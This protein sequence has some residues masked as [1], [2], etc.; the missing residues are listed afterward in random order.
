MPYDEALFDQLL[1][2]LALEHAEQRARLD[3]LRATLSPAERAARGI[4]LLDVEA[5]DESWGLGGRLL[6][7]LEKPGRAPLE[8]K[9]GVGDVVELRPRRAEVER[10]ARGVVARRTRT[11]VT[12][13]FEQLPP[14][15]VFEGRLVVDLTP[16]DVTFQRAQQAVR[17]V[18]GG[19]RRRRDVLLAR[20]PPRF[21]PPREIV[22]GAALNPEQ[23]AALERALG[24]EDFFLV[25]GP[26]VSSDAPR[27]S[28]SGSTSTPSTRWWRLTPTGS[29]RANS[30]KGHSS[31]RATP[32]A[33]VPAGGAGS[34]SPTPA[35]RAP[36][37]GRCSPRRESGSV[38]R[39]GRCW[40]G[41]RWCARPAPR[42]RVR[43]SRAK[44]ST[45]ACS[46]MPPRRSSRWR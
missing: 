38:A 3:A 17:A 26:P 28:P 16:N 37:R 44:G 45:C 6:V 4:A 21:A 24:A 23:R 8:A 29:R 33:S 46:T 10:P 13:A 14:A 12:V 22:P 31:C 7:D 20:T 27:A 30:S 5:V 25:H 2:L 36:R 19:A 42:C 41:R 43:I 35:R 9:V 1:G 32:A 34:A 18:R 11:R 40:R 39:C 15:F